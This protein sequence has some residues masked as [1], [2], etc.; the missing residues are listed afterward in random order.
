VV[1]RWTLPTKGPPFWD[2]HFARWFH[3]KEHQYQHRTI[4]RG[5]ISSCLH[6]FIRQSKKKDANLQ[7]LIICWCLL[8][9]RIACIKLDA[10]TTRGIDHMIHE[11]GWFW[12]SKNWRYY[13]GINR[14]IL[15]IETNLHSQGTRQYDRRSSQANESKIVEC[16]TSTILIGGELLWHVTQKGTFKA[17]QVCFKLSV[18][19]KGSKV[20]YI[21]PHRPMAIWSFHNNIRCTDFV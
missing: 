8:S 18:P 3:L 20:W 14:P 15:R 10:T 2:T 19:P 7:V 6:V 4:M 12:S 13:A 9:P 17:T 16:Y 1:I 5:V 21:V 11:L